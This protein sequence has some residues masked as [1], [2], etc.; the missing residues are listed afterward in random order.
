MERDR[1]I[2][3]LGFLFVLELLQRLGIRARVLLLG[4]SP[5]TFSVPV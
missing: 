2:L 1:E 4:G 5:G 3:A